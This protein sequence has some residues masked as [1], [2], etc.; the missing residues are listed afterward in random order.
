MA[1][2]QDVVNARMDQQVDQVGTQDELRSFLQSMTSGIEAEVEQLRGSATVIQQ[3]IW[4][5][6]RLL[7]SLQLQFEGSTRLPA[8]TVYLS[9]GKNADTSYTLFVNR[10]ADNVHT[11][12][13][14]IEAF[15][16]ALIPKPN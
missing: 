15:F 16:E 12:Q 5:D 7:S 11:A 1:R 6:G 2:F 8:E 9:L 13:E 4:Q 14:G 10:S 3:P